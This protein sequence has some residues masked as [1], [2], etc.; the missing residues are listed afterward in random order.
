MM[1]IDSL[2]DSDMSTDDVCMLADGI[3][4]LTNEAFPDFVKFAFNTPE[5]RKHKIQTDREIVSD[6]SLFLTKKRYIMHVVNDEGKP[7]DKL[8]NMGTEMKKSDTPPAVKDMLAELVDIILDGKTIEDAKI[9]IKEMK[10][11]YQDRELREIARPM[12]VKGLKKYEQMIEETGSDKGTPYNVR[13]AMFYNSQ[14]E[15]RHKKIVPGDKIGILYIKNPKSKYIAFPIDI[16]QFPEFMDDI[17]VDYDM[18]WDKAYKK[19]VSYMSSM[20]WD[21]ES[22]KKEQRKSLFGF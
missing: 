11:E 17:M 12:S 9:R 2:V 1:G 5:E 6:K 21:V 22:Q 4:G 13:A 10:R 14:C 15:N 18:M 8:K 16:N 3:A 7:A 20:G 19:I